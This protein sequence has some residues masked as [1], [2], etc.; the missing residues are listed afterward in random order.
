[1]FIPPSPEKAGPEVVGGGRAAAHKGQL[2][3][4][5]SRAATSLS[6]FAHVSST[7]PKE[8]MAAVS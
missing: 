3:V 8:L 4:A 1:M 6:S 2:R 7:A 5:F